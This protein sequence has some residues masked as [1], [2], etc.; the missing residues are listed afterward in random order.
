MI[1]TRVIVSLMHFLLMVLMSA[2]VIYWTYRTFIKANPDFDME[3][4][5][6]EGNIAVGLLVGTI[7]FSASQ[8]LM[9]GTDSSIQM[10]RMHMLAPTEE[11]ANVLELI[12]RMAGHL[13]ASMALASPSA[14]TKRP[15]PGP[16]TPAASST[17]PKSSSTRPLGSSST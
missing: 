6:K 11:N 13:A 5:I 15:P 3:K 17:T 10:I 9:A 4:K 14:S 8:I 2:F 7:L 16:S 12:A 1:A